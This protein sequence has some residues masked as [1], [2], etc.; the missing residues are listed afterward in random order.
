M[1]NFTLYQW[2]MYTFQFQLLHL[3]FPH[4]LYLLISCVKV[5]S[6]KEDFNGHI[7]FRKL[8]ETYVSRYQDTISK[9]WLIIYN[10][11]L[12]RQVHVKVN[13]CRIV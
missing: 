12:Y 9:A 3:H 4:Y 2:P 13:V 1:Y 6:L 8:A 5:K 11:S 10:I 7:L